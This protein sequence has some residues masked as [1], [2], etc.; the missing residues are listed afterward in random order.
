MKHNWSKLTKWLFKGDLF[1]KTRRRLT[2]QYSGVLILFLSLFVVIVYTLLHLFIWNDQYQ[3]LRNLADSEIGHLQE[4]TYGVDNPNRR[5]PH[6]VEEAFLLNSDQSFYYLVDVNGSILMGNEIRP[7]IREQLE[8]LIA[9]GQFKESG[10]HKVSLQV[11]GRQS[12]EGERTPHPQNFED[13]RYIVTERILR[14]N[15]EEI[16]TLTIGKEVTFQHDLFRLLLFLL[17]GMTLIFF[18]LAIGLS[19]QMARKAMIPISHAYTR[20]REFVA[21]ASHELRTPLS[22]MLASIEALQLEEILE[23]EPFTR[24]V[25][26]SMK[27]EVHS[28]TKL[29]ANL[30]I[31]ARSDSTEL[32]WD[33]SVFDAKAIAVQAVEKL[34]PMAKAKE[35]SMTVH[36]PAELT[37]K[38]DAE[39]LSQLLVLLIDNAIK[40]TPDHGFIEVTLGDEVE[41]G[42][43]ILTLE[44]KDSGIGIS[45][46]ALPRVFDRFYRQDKS[47]TRQNSSHGLGLA[48]AK[49]IV[50]THRGSIQVDSQ[51]GEGSTFRVRLPWTN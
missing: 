2:L 42:G 34:S 22:V 17:F 4:W 47:R 27:A 38:G 29:V 44:V 23:A 45:A 9:N 24:K 19:Y 48:I 7:E 32:S 16:A 3:R 26:T 35:I 20:Q 11:F 14:S 36:A 46:E 37:M 6:D 51:L 31:L 5:P 39:K 49:H 13:A 1:D 12:P 21:D 8:V 18:I 10:I 33:N 40:Y 28:M 15:G 25:L 50:D 41:K 43:H 30:L